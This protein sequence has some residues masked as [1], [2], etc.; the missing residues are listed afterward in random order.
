MKVLE[1]VVD[2]VCTINPQ[3]EVRVNLKKKSKIEVSKT[4]LAQVG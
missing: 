4:F 2:S 3:I 1:V